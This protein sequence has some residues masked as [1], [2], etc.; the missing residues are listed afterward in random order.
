MECRGI[1]NGHAWVVGQHGRQ[2]GMWA[3]SKPISSGCRTGTP[4][5]PGRKA[6]HSSPAVAMHRRC[7]HLKVCNHLHSAYRCYIKVLSKC[8]YM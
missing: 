4:S 3:S 7:I 6:V 1:R 2:T 5:I 8:K